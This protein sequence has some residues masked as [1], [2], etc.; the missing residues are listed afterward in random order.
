VETAL[1]YKLLFEKEYGAFRVIIVA[2]T[3]IPWLKGFC[4][5]TQQ[6]TVTSEYFTNIL[7]SRTNGLPRQTYY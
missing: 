2:S 6:L 3:N 7:G 4:S 5:H 1:G